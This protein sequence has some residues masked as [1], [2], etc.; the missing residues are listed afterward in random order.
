MADIGYG[1]LFGSV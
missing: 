1:M